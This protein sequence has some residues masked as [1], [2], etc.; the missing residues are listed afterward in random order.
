MGDRNVAAIAKRG[1]LGFMLAMVAA[2]L[3]LALIFRAATDDTVYAR[4]LDV[5]ARSGRF[6]PDY[7]PATLAVLV[8]GFIPPIPPFGMIFAAWMLMVAEKV[9]RNTIR[10]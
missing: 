8:L 10:S 5:F 4:Y 7:P 9:F 1:T 2:S 6:P 3:F